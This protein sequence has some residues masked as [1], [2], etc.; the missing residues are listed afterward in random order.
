MIVVYGKSR[1]MTDLG[2]TLQ[3]RRGKSIV[4]YY[5]AET[6]DKVEMTGGRVGD[7]LD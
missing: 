3:F 4:A 1:L 5:K 7:E 6:S 2:S